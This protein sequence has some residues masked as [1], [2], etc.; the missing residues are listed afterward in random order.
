[1]PSGRIESRWATTMRFYAGPRLPIIDE[2][3]Y[4]PPDI[5][6][7]LAQLRPDLLV[8]EQHVQ[9]IVV[10]GLLVGGSRVV[11]AGCAVRLEGCPMHLADHVTS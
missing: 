8:R 6:E 4:L 3:G 7:R 9:R 1:M 2:V 10:G 5:L 11:Y